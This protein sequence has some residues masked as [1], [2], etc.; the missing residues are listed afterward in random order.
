MKTKYFGRLVYA[1]KRYTFRGHR[2]WRGCLQL[3][4]TYLDSP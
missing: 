1:K 3:F 2:T 4:V